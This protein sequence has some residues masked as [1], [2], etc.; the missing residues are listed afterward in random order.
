MFKFYKKRKTICK[1]KV[2]CL[3]CL[4][5]Y[6]L[7]CLNVS[8]GSLWNAYAT[9]CTVQI[10]T[11]LLVW[12]EYLHKFI[13]LHR[14]YSR[15][16]VSVQRYFSLARKIT[17]LH[18]FFTSINYRFKKNCVNSRYAYKEGGGGWV[19]GGVGGWNR[20]WKLKFSMFS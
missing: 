16:V 5:V 7:E 12:T 20:D 14:A 6:C 8:K 19:G 9:V 11:Q 17:T 10:T 2:N 4:E 18:C 1:P 13:V 3:E 15:L